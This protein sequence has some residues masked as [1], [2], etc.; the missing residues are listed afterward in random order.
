MFIFDVQLSYPILIALALSLLLSR[1]QGL[2]IIAM[3][4]T[5][6]PHFHIIWSV[7]VILPLWILCIQNVFFIFSSYYLLLTNIGMVQ[8]WYKMIIVCIAA[9]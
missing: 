6:P 3:L 2:H 8:Q 5:L 4:R 9:L 7:V 1:K